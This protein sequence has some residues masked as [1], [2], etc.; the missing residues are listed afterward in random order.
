MDMLKGLWL[1]DKDV[2]LSIKEVESFFSSK[3]SLIS[4]W[5]SSNLFLIWNRGKDI[6]VFNYNKNNQNLSVES[7]KADLVTTL[8]KWNMSLNGWIKTLWEIHYDTNFSFNKHS[9]KELMNDEKIDY[10]PS[11]EIYKYYFMY[12]FKKLQENVNQL[13]ETHKFDHIYLNNHK[14]YLDSVENLFKDSL[15]KSWLP[16]IKSFF[17]E[18]QMMKIYNE[19]V[20]ND[21]KFNKLF[22]TELFYLCYISYFKDMK[23]TRSD[24]EYKWF[25]SHLIKEEWFDFIS[26]Y[27]YKELLSHIKRVERNM[28]SES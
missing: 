21:C 17:N 1:K 10:P 13:V 20:E 11:S 7:F 24:D 25:L 12:Q 22:D 16:N 27:S 26:N 28:K 14:N 3:E 6:I 18:I 23:E 19:K 5:N 9:I 2:N 8:T 15:N 4:L